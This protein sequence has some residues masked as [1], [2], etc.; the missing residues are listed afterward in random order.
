ML[1]YQIIPIESGYDEIIA[2]EEWKALQDKVEA[3]GKLCILP[4][5][6]GKIYRLNIKALHK[7]AFTKDYSINRDFG[8]LKSIA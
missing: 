2:E 3:G 8:K 6:S 4:N 5:V 1:K 7:N